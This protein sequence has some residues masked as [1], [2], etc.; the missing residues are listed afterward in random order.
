MGNSNDNKESTK[1][2]IIRWVF[3]VI[4]VIFVIILIIA[5]TSSDGATELGQVLMTLSSI[6]S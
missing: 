1:D 4:I 5:F 3:I 2:I 6:S